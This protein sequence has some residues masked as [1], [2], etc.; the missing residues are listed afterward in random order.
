MGNLQGVS[1]ALEECIRVTRLANP[2]AAA[3][4][5]VTFRAGFRIT[6]HNWEPWLHTVLPVLLPVLREAMALGGSHL[7]RELVALDQNGLDALPKSMQEASAR[8]GRLL[9]KH[10]PPN[11]AKALQKL[12]VAAGKGDT[13][14]HLATVFGARCGVF[15]IGARVAAMAYVFQ[16]LTLGAPDWSEIQIASR[17]EEARVVVENILAPKNEWSES[18]G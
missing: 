13:P 3:M 6:D 1:A 4:G 16:E 10:S 14:G 9:L 15:S 7:G 12:T 2:A 8:A 18:H 11:G 5:P 17:L